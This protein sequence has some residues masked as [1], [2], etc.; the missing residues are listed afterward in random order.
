M[1][2]SIRAKSFQCDQQL[3]F[4]GFCKLVTE[5]ATTS[6]L[7]PIEFILSQLFIA[8]EGQDEGKPKSGILLQLYRRE[9]R[10]IFHIFR[11]MLEFFGNCD[12]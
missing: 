3:E 4:Y 2:F 10:Q 8:G 6:L 9:L 12:S 5:L 11:Q 7:P 1:E